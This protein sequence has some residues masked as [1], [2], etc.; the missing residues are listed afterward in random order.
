[1]KKFPYVVIWNYDS[2]PTHWKE[3]AAFRTMDDGIRFMNSYPRVS[4]C[5][6][7][8]KPEKPPTRGK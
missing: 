8:F 4:W 1:M 5:K 7:K 6:Y 3:V 2:D